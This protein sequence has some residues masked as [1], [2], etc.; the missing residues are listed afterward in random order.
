LVS[1]NIFET[2]VL[3]TLIHLLA[4]PGSFSKIED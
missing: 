3:E 2:L 4:F 1:E